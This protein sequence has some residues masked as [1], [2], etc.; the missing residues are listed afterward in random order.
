MEILRQGAGFPPKHSLDL[1]R[2]MT[3]VQ[4]SERIETLGGVE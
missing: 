2:W 3:V 4:D 1:L